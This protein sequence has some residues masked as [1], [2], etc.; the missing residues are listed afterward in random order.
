MQGVKFKVL[1]FWHAKKSNMLAI[2]LEKYMGMGMAA[3]HFGVSGMTFRKSLRRCNLEYPRI[4]P[5]R[6]KVMVRFAMQR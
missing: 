3:S 2:W 1:K 6:L 4:A 5:M